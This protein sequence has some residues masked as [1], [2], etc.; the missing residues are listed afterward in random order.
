MR[1][2]GTKDDVV[3]VY[4]LGAIGLF[5]VQYAKYLGC[6]K[7]IAVDINDEKLAVAEKCGA[8]HIVNSAKVDPLKD[9]LEYTDGHGADLCLEMSGFPGAQAQ[10]VLSAGKMGRIVYLGIS[11][12]GLELPAEAVD[13]IERYQLSIIGS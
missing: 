11:H 8:T 4:G 12:A 9:I 6:K 5:A 7:I 13:N 2:Q 10:A 1:G 3:C